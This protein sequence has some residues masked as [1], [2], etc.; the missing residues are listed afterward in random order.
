M[1]FVFHPS[2]TTALQAAASLP[3][4]RRLAWFNHGFQKAEVRDGVLVLS[5]LRMGR[6][7]DYFFRFA[8]A[9]RGADGGW[10]A[11]QPPR[12]ARAYAA[13]GSPGATPAASA[14]K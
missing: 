7:P 6:E 10:R 3:A 13:A 11:L 1:R 14:S 12:N 8:V 5:D 4:V 9:E 2:D